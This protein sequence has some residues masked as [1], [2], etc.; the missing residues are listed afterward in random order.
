[1]KKILLS[2]LCLVFFLTA[3]S[4]NGIIDSETGL[5]GVITFDYDKSNLDSQ[6]KTTLLNLI[7]QFKVNN[8]T[9]NGFTDSDGDL[10]YNKALSK[11]RAENVKHFL[12]KNGYPSSKIVRINANGEIEGGVKAFNRKVEIY[13]DIETIPPPE[14]VKE[15]NEIEELKPLLN[16]LIE[17]KSI[18]LKNQIL[19]LAIGQTLAISDLNF[20]PGRHLL[21]PESEP[22]LNELLKILKDNPTLNIEIQGHI[23]CMP[24]NSDGLDKDTRTMN[25]SVN[26][27]KYI[28]NY[29][30]EHDISPYQLS[31]KGF[32]AS[33]P[34]VTEI[35]EEDRI[36]NRRVEIMIIDK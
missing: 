1:M 28:Y 2:L 5:I 24:L 22:I 17:T 13:L 10:A 9:I 32:G 31:F 25:L 19:N 29:L 15:I 34:L 3:Q 4:Q 16:E 21:L 11:R 27:A 33:K 36:K 30:L 12:V 6:D 23:C 18:S 35:T 14:I 7:K 20:I 8:I 26:R